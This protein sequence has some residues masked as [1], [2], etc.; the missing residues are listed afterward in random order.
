MVCIS[1]TSN[2][3]DWKRATH[4][5][6]PTCIISVKRDK[7]ERGNFYF[8]WNLFEGNTEMDNH[9]DETLL[10]TV[11]PDL[12]PFLMILQTPKQWFF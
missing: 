9:E 1:T 8:L 5:L 3:K 2:W 12:I 7:E 4:L 11:H 10:P 6:C